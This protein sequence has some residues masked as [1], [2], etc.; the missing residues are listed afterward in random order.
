MAT[1]PPMTPRRWLLAVTTAGA[2]VAIVLTAVWFGRLLFDPQWNLTLRD[3]MN[4]Q[5]DAED[6]TTDVSET[7]S[8]VCTPALP[9]VEAYDTAE[10]TYLRFGSRDEAT[11]YASSL[12]DGFQSNYIVMDFAGKD[13]VSKT[14]QLWA[15]Q[16]LAGIWQDYEGEFPDR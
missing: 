7:T 16:Y 9:C 12:Q 8:S 5:P 3:V 13:A 2:V 4:G 10:A 15:M 6:P 14:Q 11:Q 1:N